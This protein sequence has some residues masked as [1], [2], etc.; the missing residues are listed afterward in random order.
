MNSVSKTQNGG[1]D[2]TQDQ[3]GRAFMVKG[4][5]ND[6]GVHFNLDP[7]LLEQLQNASGFEPAL[8]QFRPLDFFSFLGL[9]T[10]QNNTALASTR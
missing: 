5:N 3:L 1:I 6:P 9:D 4:E 10:R 7:A 8:I 2:L